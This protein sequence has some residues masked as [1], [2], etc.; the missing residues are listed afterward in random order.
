[1]LRDQAMARKL[2]KPAVVR[3][4]ADG[5]NP[6]A[7]RSIPVR[8]IVQPARPA[9]AQR[10]REAAWLVQ[11]PIVAVFVGLWIA[12]AY[13]TAKITPVCPDP[14]VRTVMIGGALKLAGC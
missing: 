14:S 11:V 9:S 4:G 2:A 12:M 7:R 10:P 1:L 13:F 5:Q 6:V 3:T 8:S